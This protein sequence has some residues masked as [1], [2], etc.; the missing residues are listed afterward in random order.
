MNL[1]LS[2]TDLDQL[3]WFRAH[4]DMTLEELLDRFRK[5]EETEA[6]RRGT[7]FHKFLE[8]ANDGE[9]GS[10]EIDGYK[11]RFDL[12][13]EVS[14]PT[15]RELKATREYRAHGVTVTL[16]GKLDA[17][18][19]K[20]V[21]DHKLTGQFQVDRYCDSIQWRCYLAIFDADAFRYN[22]FEYI[23]DR[24]TGD[25]VVRD[26]HP[27]NFYRY[28]DLEAEVER[29]VGEFVL[30]AKQHLPERFTQEQAA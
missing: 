30:F 17:M 20:R 25:L 15:I 29:E 10:V 1:R 27:L 21:D 22:I 2:V 13:A 24:Q 7:A 11:F 18:H 8:T 5:R 3:Q 26:Y 28:P 4:E 19:G 23:E 9:F 6:M 12:D 16:V 14:L